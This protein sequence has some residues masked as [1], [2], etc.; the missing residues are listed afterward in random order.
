MR[1][2]LLLVLAALVLAAIAAP[3]ALAHGAFPRTIPLPDGL[4]PEGITI[5]TGATFYVGSIPTGAIYRGDLRTGRGAVLVPGVEG[6]AAIGIDHHRGLLFVAGGPTGKAFVYH[7]RTG[8]LVREVQ[9]ATGPDA[10]FVNDVVVTRTA[11]YF[12][13]SNRAVLYKLPLRRHGW[14]AASARVIPLSGDVRLV[15]GFNLNGIVATPRSLISVQ[16]ATGMLF[17]VDPRSGATREIDLGGEVLTNGDGLL[18]RGRMLYVVR[19]QDNQIAVVRLS[20]HFA[21]GR[22][23]RTIMDPAFDVPTTVDDFGR[24]LY[25]VNARFGTPPTPETEYDVVRVHR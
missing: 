3:A 20:R 6:R 7:A 12:T 8:A 16:S 1:R 5:G 22:V 14:P 24:F 18:L 23:V 13:D 19:N 15:D 21:A 10:T 4:Q 17:L 2:I 9:L 11:A 25:V